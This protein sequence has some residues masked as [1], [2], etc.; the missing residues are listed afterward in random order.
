MAVGTEQAAQELAHDGDRT[1]V[2][3]ARMRQRGRLIDAPAD[4]HT[5]Q[6]NHGGGELQRQHDRPLA[7]I[8]GGG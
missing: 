7:F 8:V 2:L 6:R 4:T 5:R 3:R 1:V